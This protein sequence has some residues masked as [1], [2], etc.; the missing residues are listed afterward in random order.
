MSF[1]RFITGSILFINIFAEATLFYITMKSY[2]ALMICLISA[3]AFCQK[4]SQPTELKIK[5]DYSHPAT[6]TVFPELW[7]GFQRQAV[8]SYNAGNTNVGISYVQQPSKKNKTALTFY[9]Y[10]KEYIDN[11]ML[12]DEFYSYDYALNQN[13]NTHVKIKPSFGTLSG[14][15]LKVSSIYSVF[16][17]ALGQQDFFKGVK[18]VD[19]NSLL[20][21]YECGGWTFKI[22][23]SSD[24]MTPEQLKELKDKAENYF[25]VLQIAFVKPLPVTKV[26]DILLSASVKRDS[27][28]M[29]AVSEAAKAKIAYLSQNLDKKEL[30]TG[31]HDTKIDSEVHSLEKMLDYY[32]AHE[33][34]WQLHPD[35]KKYF[36]EMS[37]IAQ[38]GR[39]KDHI[40]EMYH[41]LIDY[42]AGENRTADY[43]QFKIDQNIS[44]DTNE[45][46]YK[47]FY[48]LD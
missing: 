20:S 2:L 8:V 22:R 3:I 17:N 10:P 30:L 32:Q 23:A 16:K 36:D 29:N 6:K 41:G 28:M 25:G 35:T 19:K 39:L 40:Y 1:C 7:S 27:M 11:Q 13:S 46:F 42:P 24:D 26:P 4:K 14:D 45:I 12:R 21:I 37:R 9:I 44:E 47:I 38:N 48:N 5:G 34:D 31:F 15:S 43:I 18:Y 33:R